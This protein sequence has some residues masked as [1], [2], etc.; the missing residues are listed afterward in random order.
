[1]PTLSSGPFEPT[2]ASLKHE[3]DDYKKLVLL[4]KDAYNYIR[5]NYSSSMACI[6]ELDLYAHP[7][8][9]WRLFDEIEYPINDLSSDSLFKTVIGFLKFR[10]RFKE[11]L[12]IIKGICINYTSDEEDDLN[13]EDQELTDE[14][15]VNSSSGEESS[16]D[17][18]DS[19]EELRKCKNGSLFPTI[20][21]N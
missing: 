13:L 10:Q 16:G 2:T 6:Y 15:S 17:S 8:C 11:N 19:S 18:T 1:M 9:R 3:E 12:E 5:E 21:N 4:S 20:N 7:L 14:E